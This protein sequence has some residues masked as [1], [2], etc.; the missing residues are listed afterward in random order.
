M[1][2]LYIYNI[3]Y[4]YKYYHI[5]IC[6]KIIYKNTYT[7]LYMYK[8]HGYSNKGLGEIPFKVGTKTIKKTQE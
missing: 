1:E 7:Y 6:I 2:V 8:N 5:C 3:L 4:D